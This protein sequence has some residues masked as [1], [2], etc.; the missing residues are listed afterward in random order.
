MPRPST[1]PEPWLSLA[2][3]L[4]GVRGLSEALFCDPRTVNRWAHKQ[5]TPDV[6]T[7]AFIGKLF[8]NHG[9]EPPTF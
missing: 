9:I 6:R 2:N 5:T 7:Q 3:Q 8:E 1:L 4:V